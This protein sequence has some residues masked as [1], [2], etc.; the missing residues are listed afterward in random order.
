L[1]EAERAQDR[2][3]FIGQPRTNEQARLR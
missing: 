3:G 2:S 1:R